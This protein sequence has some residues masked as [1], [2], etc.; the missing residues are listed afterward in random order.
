MP[1][2]IWKTT[3]AENKASEL[4]YLDLTLLRSRRYAAWRSGGEKR[5]VGLRAASLRAVRLHVR[6]DSGRRCDFWVSS[7]E[8]GRRNVQNAI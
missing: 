8:D 4:I 6:L 5:R 1:P 3:R 7:E 2:T